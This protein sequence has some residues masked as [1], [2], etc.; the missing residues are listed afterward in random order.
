MK[1]VSSLII[2]IIPLISTAQLKVTLYG[3][4]KDSSMV[5][6]KERYEAKGFEVEILPEAR[7]G[8]EG[9]THPFIMKWTN[10]KIPEFK[11]TDLSGETVTLED[12]KGKRIHIN[13]WSVTCKPCIQEFP[14]L[15]QLK[16]KYPDW[17]F[18]AIAPEGAKRVNKILGKQNLDYQ[19]I[20][21]AEAYFNLLGI[22][23]Y[24]KN[25]FIDEEGNI[26]KVTDGTHYTIKKVDGEATMIPDN[27]RI[28]DE[29][30][31]NF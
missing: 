2:L 30:I 4:E 5:K 14:E 9:E 7:I 27:F 18:I 15:N 19:V 11:L 10:K 1:T 6:Q 16:K 29:I 24:P 28:Y 22:D 23:G 17:V 31:S 3:N 25:F 21:E 12:F 13:F 20:A 8:E 26:R